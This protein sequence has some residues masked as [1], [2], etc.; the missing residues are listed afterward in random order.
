MHIVHAGTVAGVFDA[1]ESIKR[2][3]KPQRYD[4]LVLPVVISGSDRPAT[5]PPIA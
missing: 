1:A 2:I 4:I 5:N 3:F